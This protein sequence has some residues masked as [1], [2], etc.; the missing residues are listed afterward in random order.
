MW[1]YIGFVRVENRGFGAVDEIDAF[2]RSCVIS[3]FRSKLT[4]LIE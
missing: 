3:D 2:E 4:T 1:M